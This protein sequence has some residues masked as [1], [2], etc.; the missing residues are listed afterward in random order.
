[1]PIRNYASSEAGRRMSPSDAAAYP[2]GS[3]STTFR[4]ADTSRRQLPSSIYLPGDPPIIH[5]PRPHA[6]TS[7]ND[8]GGLRVLDRSSS[9]SVIAVTSAVSKRCELTPGFFRITSSPGRE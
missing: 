8:L 1:M 2:G 6:R 9:S 5:V 4:L 3:V 7:D